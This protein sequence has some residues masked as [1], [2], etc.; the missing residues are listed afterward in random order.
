MEEPRS[1]RNEEFASLCSLVN[2]VFRSNGVGKMEEQY[3]LLFAP[4]NFDHLLV[5]VDDGEVVSHVGALTRDISTA[6]CRLSTMSIGA[7]ATCAAYRGRGLATGL[8]DM[9]IRK[10]IHGG[11]SLMLISG[12]RGL[13]R[14]LGAK[15]AGRFIRYVVPEGAIAAGAVA[16]ESLAERAIDKP[17][18]GPPGLE[19]LNFRPATS[20]DL[21]GMT[22]MY[23]EESS[24][25]VRSTTD[26][27]TAVESEWICDSA[28]ET[29]VILHNNR[30]VSYAGIQQS[31]IDRHRRDR[32]A[33]IME[34]GRS[35][36]ALLRA[37]P[38][39][40][41][42]YKVNSIEIVSTESDTELSCLTE[43]Y[44]IHSIPQE[45]AGTVIVLDQKRLLQSIKEYITGI[46]GRGVLSWDIS[47]DQSV[48]FTCEGQ[49]HAFPKHVLSLLVFGEVKAEMNP[50]DTLATGPLRSALETVFPI[51]LPWYGFNFV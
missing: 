19:E 15:R 49:V 3:P 11:T 14:R 24:R 48:E 35:R 9:A 44:G 17:R 5:M 23:R 2:S 7:V 41:K 31:R 51:Q 8:M 32:K 42:R 12:G 25:Y 39:L 47:F 43:P 13:Y 46:L 37:L 28:G 33:D 22:R 1:L 10:A 34:M 36:S 38:A 50:L 21:P 16:D 6:G 4:E 30:I 18:V 20:N 45:Y 26:F 40:Y 27:A 29:L